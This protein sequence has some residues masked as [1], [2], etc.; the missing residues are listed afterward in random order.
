[1]G[2]PDP[3]VQPFPQPG[4]VAARP[5]PQAPLQQQ[6]PSPPL[7]PPLPRLPA[8]ASAAVSAAAAALAAAFDVPLVEESAAPAGPRPLLDLFPPAA[9]RDVPAPARHFAPVAHDRPRPPRNPMAP[10]T[11]AATEPSRVP[12][13]RRPRRASAAPSGFTYE[14]FYGLSENP[15]GLSP[16]LRFLYQSGS[17]DRVVQDLTAAVGRRDGL[18]VLTGELGIGKT[19]LCRALVDQL[20]RRT[21]VSF[22]TDPFSAADEL[23]KTVLVDFGVISRDDVAN[24]RLA[25]TSVADLAGKLR[26]FLASLAVL[27]AV[28]LLIIDDAHKL[29]AGASSGLRVLSEMAAEQKLLQVVLV[30][31]PELAKL[32]RSADLR[33]LD[34]LVALRAELDPLAAEEIPGYV[35]HRLAVAGSTGR[36]EFDDEA[37]A[38]VYAL[39][40]GVPR[41]VNLICDRSL[42][43]GY[44]SSAAVI[45]DAIVDRAAREL[46]L[47]PEAGTSWRDHLVLAALMLALMLAGAAGAG[48]VFRAPLAR[49]L[50][51]WHGVGVGSLLQ[52]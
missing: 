22:V 49:A 47:V 35:A 51:Q 8:T 37:L 39:S 38:R 16:D 18:I 28:A 41:V 44:R 24:G 43:I 20:D 11:I 13:A 12:A 48:W 21:L 19:T 1:M 25:E 2:D 50:A 32:L 23:L 33:P 26:D 30:G 45:D 36:V 42:T 40:Q 52:K 5:S 4:P 7:S 9:A 15:F 17:H 14:S 27:Q 34:G 3:K 29:P 46:A 10:P 6:P 31:E